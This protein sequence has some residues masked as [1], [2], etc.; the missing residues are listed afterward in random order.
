ML[1]M[2]GWVDMYVYIFARFNPP[3]STSLHKGNREQVSVTPK[4]GA[5]ELIKSIALCVYRAR[6]IEASVSC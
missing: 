2:Y 1:C 6:L 3:S 4:A 5:F